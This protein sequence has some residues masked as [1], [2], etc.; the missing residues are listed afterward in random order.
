MSRPWISTNLAISADG[1]I[2]SAGH[3]ASNW[4][5]SADHGRLLALRA[6][7]DALMVGR[8]TLVVDRMS[9]IVPGKPIQPLRCIVSS[10]AGSI[11]PDHPLLQT[12]GGAVLW[13]VTG[14][15]VSS[16]PDGVMIH[17]SSLA[18]FLHE[19]ASTHGVRH[20]HCEGGGQLVRELASMD[21]I[22]EFHAT[23]AGHAVFGGANAPT[24]TGIP[25]AFLQHS[26][27]F[28]L[29]CFEPHPDLGECF[30]SYRRR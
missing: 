19:L 25:A 8:G 18:V 13:L 23:I 22:D 26:A 24:A 17:R 2:S 20:L 14:V 5:S 29:S 10:G 6:G 21:V 1:K 15:P 7:A 4:T 11:P 12:K 9:M 28:E 27:E 16:L 3:Q 30:V